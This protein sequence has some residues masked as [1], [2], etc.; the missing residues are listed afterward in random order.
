MNVTEHE[1]LRYK[2][3]DYKENQLRII[4][5][6][7]I[8]KIGIQL[9]DIKLENIFTSDTLQ[10]YY[11]I[12]HMADRLSSE[13]GLE[14]MSALR[15]ALIISNKTYNLESESLMNSLVQVKKL[16]MLS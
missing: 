1:L 3:V 9:S 12:I 6:R 13:R 7:F 10:E 15:Q 2:N 5:E 16:S 4:N 8:A 14:Y 11:E